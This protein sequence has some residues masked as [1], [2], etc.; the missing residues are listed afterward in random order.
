MTTQWCDRV[1]APGVKGMSVVDAVDGSSTGTRVPMIFPRGIS[2][3][4][5]QRI[6]L[7]E[8]EILDQI[9]DFGEHSESYC[10]DNSAPEQGLAPAHSPPGLMAPAY[11]S[12]N[13]S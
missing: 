5:I 7:G 6:L 1:R 11:A 13:V 3:S 4:R 12:R 9:V 8:N 2:R 10:D